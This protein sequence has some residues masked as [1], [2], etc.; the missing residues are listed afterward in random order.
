[1]LSKLVGQLSPNCRGLLSV[2]L[3]CTNIVSY[4]NVSVVIVNFSSS[5]L[6]VLDQTFNDSVLPAFQ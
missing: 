5:A 3:P 4:V 1:M 2:V 6:Q